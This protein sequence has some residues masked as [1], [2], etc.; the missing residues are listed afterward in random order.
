MAIAP[1]VELHQRKESRGQ[2]NRSNVEHLGKTLIRR[3]INAEVLVV[4]CW[5]LAVKRKKALKVLG[6]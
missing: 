2:E 4:I 6:C 5:H 3:R 1:V